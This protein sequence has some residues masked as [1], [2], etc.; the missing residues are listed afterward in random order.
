MKVC[1]LRAHTRGRGENRQ[2]DVRTPHWARDARKVPSFKF[3]GS[4]KVRHFAAVIPAA[5]HLIPG[6]SRTFGAFTSSLAFTSDE[7]EIGFARRLTPVGICVMRYRSAT[8]AGSHGFPCICRM[9]EKNFRK[10]TNPMPLVDSQ[11]KTHCKT[12]VCAFLSPVFPSYA[13]AENQFL[14]LS[15]HRI[16]MQRYV[17]FHGFARHHRCGKCPAPAPRRAH[18]DH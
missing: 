10:P 17:Y 2:S 15:Y 1:R 4:R 5:W 3:Q 9:N 12:E 13:S 7:S 11:A 18:C 8:V 16:L 14:H 6:T